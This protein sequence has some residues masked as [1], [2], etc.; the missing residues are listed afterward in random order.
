MEGA[1][2][3]GLGSEGAFAGA[4]CTAWVTTDIPLG[5][6]LVRDGAVDGKGGV[7]TETGLSGKGSDLNTEGHWIVWNPN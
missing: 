3:A 4:C 5:T 1:G 7:A 2:L 6:E